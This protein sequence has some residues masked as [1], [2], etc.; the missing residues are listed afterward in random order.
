[1]SL[2]TRRQLYLFWF[3][4]W[5]IHSGMRTAIWLGWM[6]CHSKYVKENVWSENSGNL[7]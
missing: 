5:H 2:E 4:Q 6:S 1:M 7:K 3:T